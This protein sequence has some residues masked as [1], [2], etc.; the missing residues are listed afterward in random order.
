MEVFL[1]LGF[2]LWLVLF[3]LEAIRRAVRYSMEQWYY[4]R[5][6][7]KTFERWSNERKD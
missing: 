4:R 7:R 1:E 3:F 2:V 6:N 5:L